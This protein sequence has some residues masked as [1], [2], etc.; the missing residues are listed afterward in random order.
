MAII[1]SHCGACGTELERG[2]R[3]V[4]DHIVMR[5]PVCRWYALQSDG[6]RFFEADHASH[7]A[8]V[9]E[10]KARALELDR[11]KDTDWRIAAALD[12][13]DDDPRWHHW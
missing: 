13:P 12:S 11:E 3:F 8:L 6:R 1:V 4:P 5:C 2:V 7:D 9:G 10:L